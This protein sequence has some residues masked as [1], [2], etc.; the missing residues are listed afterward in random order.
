M[1]GD[2]GNVWVRGDMVAGSE[3]MSVR[4]FD[5][6]D[7]SA[8]DS[9]TLTTR[10][11][12]H[13]PIVTAPDFTASHNQNIGASSLF[14]VSDA[15]NDTINNYQFWDSTADP[16]SGHWLVGGVAQGTNHA[17]D[18]TAAQLARTT[19]QSGSGSDDL[20]IRAN[21][22]LL[23]SD[24][25]EFHVNAP[26]NH[27]ATVTAPG[28]TASHNQNIAAS[29]LFSVSDADNDTITNYQFWDSTTDPTS[30]HWL[31]GGVAQG[32]NQAIDVTAAQLSQ[33]TFQSAS[34]S[35][36]LWVRAFDGINWSAWKEFLVSAPIDA[37][38][39]V[40]GGNASLALNEVVAASSLF[41]VT[42]ADNDTMT[43]Y[44][45]WD[46]TAAPASA[47]FSVNGTAQSANHAVDV[48]AS[49]LPQVNVVGGSVAGTDQL[50]VRTNDGA[51]WS[52]WY[53]FMAVTH[54]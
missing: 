13:A 52:D 18:V 31:V 33:T 11:I 24:W 1:A 36:D 41:S 43:E 35:D 7:W 40:A 34:G 53:S 32:A 46:S 42:D 39:V 30:G 4:A 17:I 8:W 49:N 54:A 27:A 44:Q 5:G 6:I 38:P 45:F 50:W 28:F 9:F 2:L 48:M 14:S 15:D 10:P 16:T 12:N 47:H 25:K 22:G 19:F 23:W 37:K 51:V 21:D 20:W 26:A 3:T 29:S